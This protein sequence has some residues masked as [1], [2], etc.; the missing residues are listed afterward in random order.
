MKIEN[1]ILICAIISIISIIGLISNIGY[2]LINHS[3]P[4]TPYLLIFI[5]SGGLSL[6]IEGELRKKYNV[7]DNK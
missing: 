7:S 4:F 2:S 3:T 6:F 5:M 1:Q